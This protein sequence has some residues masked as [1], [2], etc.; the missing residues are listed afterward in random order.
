MTSI[1]EKTT[2]AAHG[3][4]KMPVRREIFE[5][6]AAVQKDPASA[7]AAKVKAIADYLSTIQR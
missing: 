3:E 6:G 1:E 4:S 7:S 2:I 5:K